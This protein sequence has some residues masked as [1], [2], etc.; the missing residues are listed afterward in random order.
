[1]SQHMAV[2]L[3]SSYLDEEVTQAQLR[4]VEDHLSACSECRGT[5]AGLSSIAAL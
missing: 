2:E 1:M 3:L 4:L 5:L